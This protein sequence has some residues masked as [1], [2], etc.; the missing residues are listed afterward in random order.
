MLLQK[1]TIM[2]P[3]EKYIWRAV[4]EQVDAYSDIVS[5]VDKYNGLALRFL[6]FYS[7][8]LRGVLYGEG[9]NNERF[10]KDFEKEGEN[11]FIE[12]PEPEVLENFKKDTNRI[13]R[14]FIINFAKLESDNIEALKSLKASIENLDY[15]TSYSGSKELKYS[16]K[17]IDNK[18]SEI[19]Q[20]S[21]EKEPSKK[22]RKSF[23]N[24]KENFNEL[25]TS[26]DP[27]YV[28]KFL[29]FLRE[30]EIISKDNKWLNSKKTTLLGLVD[31]LK[32]HGII[33]FTTFYEAGSLFAEKF[34]VDMN[35]RSYTNHTAARQDAFQGFK[36][37]LNDFIRQYKSA[38]S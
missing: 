21:R 26:S 31:A 33:S 16:R 4:L 24:R 18:I 23:Y 12:C 6:V 25:F 7:N 19:E 14:V 27:E 8:I 10:M 17:F 28:N 22:K 29:E 2:I 1:D 32:Y 38:T 37:L 11:Y 36:F 34:N 9:F 35:R 5:L 15:F 3:E 20:K 30:N 13:I